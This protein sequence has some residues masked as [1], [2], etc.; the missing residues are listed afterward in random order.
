MVEGV[1]LDAMTVLRGGSQ[2]ER[3]YR[4]VRKKAQP[5][6]RVDICIGLEWPALRYRDDVCQRIAPPDSGLAE[7]SEHSVSVSVSVDCLAK[8]HP[9]SSTEHLDDLLLSY[10]SMS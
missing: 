7:H 9:S 2:R 6:L 4:C 10:S 5:F 3:H 8:G 1:P